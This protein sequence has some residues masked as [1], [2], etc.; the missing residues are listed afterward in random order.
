MTLFQAII[1]GIVQ[2]LT[3]FIPVSS[4][5]HLVFASRALDLYDG[6]EAALRA[7]QTTATIAVVQLGTLLAALIYFE[8][9]IKKIT[10]AVIGDDLAL[11]RGSN[12]QALANGRASGRRS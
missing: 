6:V 11:I 2:G 4:T 3:E 5:A 1:L 12:N 9:D 8:R 7:Q 10:R